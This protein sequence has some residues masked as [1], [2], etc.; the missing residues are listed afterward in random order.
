M[1]AAQKYRLKTQ[2]LMLLRD[3]GGVASP[4]LDKMG[5]TIDDLK[6]LVPPDAIKSDDTTPVGELESA[7][8]AKALSGDVKALEILLAAALPEK[9]DSKIRY[10]RWRA[11]ERESGAALPDIVFEIIDKNISDEI[12]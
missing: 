12:N 4:V 3:Y 7:L 9:Y 6:A 11:Q 5:I 10:D 1:D 2:A 8:R